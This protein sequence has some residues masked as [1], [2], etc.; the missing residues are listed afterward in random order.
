MQCD[1]ALLYRDSI[2]ERKDEGCDEQR[3]GKDAS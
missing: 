3:E 2:T 1:V